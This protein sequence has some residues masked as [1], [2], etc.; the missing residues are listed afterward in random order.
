MVKTLGNTKKISLKPSLWYIK[1]VILMPLKYKTKTC[2]MFDQN[3]QIITFQ[4]NFRPYNENCEQM[5]HYIGCDLSHVKA[6][7]FA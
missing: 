5:F 6:I 7:N 4:K 1:L 2:S 3:I